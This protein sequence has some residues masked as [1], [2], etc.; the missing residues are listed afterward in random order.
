MKTNKANTHN[1]KK[2][3]RRKKITD[4][5]TGINLPNIHLVKGRK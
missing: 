1:I 2:N 5:H 3:K 4:K